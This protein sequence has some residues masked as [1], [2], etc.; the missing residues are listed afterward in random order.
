[1]VF[2]PQSWWR[3]GTIDCIEK[4]FAIILGH[5]VLL[6]S[7][8]HI[9]LNWRHHSDTVC[10]WGKPMAAPVEAKQ[11]SPKFNAKSNGLSYADSVANSAEQRSK[12]LKLLFKTSAKFRQ[13][14]SRKNHRAY[15]NWLVAG[16]GK[17][18]P[19]RVH[20]LLELIQCKFIAYLRLMVNILLK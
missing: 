10:Y 3:G 14:D 1:M 2:V 9:A 7:R 18:A 4:H 13:N 6:S 19:P 12:L 20:I 15:K 5:N 11:T 17:V 16:R 8:I